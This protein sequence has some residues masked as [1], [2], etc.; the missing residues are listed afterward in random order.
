[1]SASNLLNITDVQSLSNLAEFLRQEPNPD[2]EPI[3]DSEEREED[4]DKKDVPVVL[5][6]V[7]EYICQNQ[8]CEYL[9]NKNELESLHVFQVDSDNDIVICNFCYDKGNRFCLFTHEVMHL[10]KLEPVLENMYAQPEHNQNQLNPNILS[11]VDDIDQYLQIIGID[12]PNPTH[13]IIDLIA[14][15]DLIPEIDLPK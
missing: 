1:M 4:P 14:E 12:N 9:A 6:N 10:S 13:T 5:S 3:I 8:T 2:I 11:V 7:D 15:S